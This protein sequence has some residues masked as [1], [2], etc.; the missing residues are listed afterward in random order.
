MESGRHVSYVIL[1]WIIIIKRQQIVKFMLLHSKNALEMISED[2][3]IQK[4]SGGARSQ[5]GPMLIIRE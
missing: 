3:N 2:P 5:T 4:L 1:L